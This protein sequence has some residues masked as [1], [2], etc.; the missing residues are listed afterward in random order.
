MEKKKELLVS[1]SKP[2]EKGRNRRGENFQA[3]L[4]GQSVG[5]QDLERRLH[6]IQQSTG[7]RSRLQREKKTG[8]RN[9]FGVEGGGY[10]VNNKARK[11][12]VHKKGHSCLKGKETAEC[13]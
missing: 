2:E 8:R 1:Q 5:S 10:P 7:G 3:L 13:P 6:D 9:F 4:S 12:E 11:E